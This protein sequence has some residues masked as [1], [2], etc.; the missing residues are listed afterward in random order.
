LTSEI[1]VYYK[2]KREGSNLNSPQAQAP[3]II[4]TQPVANSQPIVQTQPVAESQPI[5][6]LQAPTI[7]TVALVRA[8]DSNGVKKWALSKN[9]N[10]SIVQYIETINGAD[11]IQLYVNRFSKLFSCFNIIKFYFT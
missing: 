9:L 6:E 1:N 10:A 2:S 8:W 5:A 4:Q 11:L 3:P 7:S